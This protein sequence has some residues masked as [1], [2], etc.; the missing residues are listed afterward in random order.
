MFP[1]GKKIFRR[2]QDSRN[3]RGGDKPVLYVK[4]MNIISRG[5]KDIGKYIHRETKEI[6]PGDVSLKDIL[7][8]YIFHF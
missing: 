4:L 2:K 5:K 8:T 7:C 6:Y 1:P 3:G